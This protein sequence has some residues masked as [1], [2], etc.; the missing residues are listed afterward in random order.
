MTASLAWLF[1]EVTVACISANKR[2]G[3][4]KTSANDLTQTKDS[5]IQLR[6]LSTK[7]SIILKPNINTYFTDRLITVSLFQPLLS[8]PLADFHVASNYLTAEIG[9]RYHMDK[10]KRY[11]KRS[12][13]N[14]INDE[15]SKAIEEEDQIEE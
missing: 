10:H 8:Y 7:L 6:Y 12:K 15:Q 13:Y 3:E 4:L 1:R 5:K 2:V 11:N 14:H 9:T